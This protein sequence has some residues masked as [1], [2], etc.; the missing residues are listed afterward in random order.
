VWGW[1]LLS[2]AAIIA[3]SL[4][5]KDVEIPANW[6]ESTSDTFDLCVKMQFKDPLCPPIGQAAVTSSNIDRT[7]PGFQVKAPQGELTAENL[8]RATTLYQLG[9][10]PLAWLIG[11][12]LDKPRSNKISPR[13]WSEVQYLYARILFD[14]RKYKE[15]E[16]VFD[17]AVEVL[18]GRAVIHQERAWVYL[19]N[20]KWDKALG[21]LVS[22]ESPLIRD[23]PFFEKYFVRALVERD[24]CN[25]PAAF[26]TIAKGREFLKSAVADQ[27]VD[28]H[29]WVL[30]CEKKNLGPICFDLRQFYK[31]YF[32][33]KIK[34]ALDDLDIL[35][36]EMRDRG[37]APQKDPSYSEIIW[38]YEGEN[39]KDELG[40]YSVPVQTRC[41]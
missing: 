2:S 11:L 35:E 23:V 12:H 10:A 27:A 14:Q 5:S 6:Y 7:H 3:L 16:I 37:L 30:T 15:S 29:P 31:A 13:L 39:W 32:A 9:Q 26:T 41:G 36:I 38:P 18:K 20:G 8:Y 33:A 25:W 4:I 40:Y 17:R 24:T 19:F 1:D 28:K 21:S 34:R 22:A